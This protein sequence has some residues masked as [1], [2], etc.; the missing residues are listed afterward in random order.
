MALNVPNLDSRTYDQLVAEAQRRILRFTPDWT[1]FNPSDPGVTLVELFA[2]LTEITLYQ[3]NQV[4]DLTYVKFL[5][6]IGLQQNP[7]APAVAEVTFTPTARTA[8]VVVPARSQ[9]SATGPTGLPLVFET[10]Q[11]LALVPYQLTDLVVDDGQ[12]F[13]TV[14]PGAPFRPLGWIP[15][16]NNA[17]YLGFAPTTATE[18]GQ[19]PQELRLL[20]TL[21]AA[22]AAGAPQRA[23][24][25]VRPPLAPVTL[26]WEYL[27]RPDAT[28]WSRL[29][30]LAD[31]SAAFTAQGYVTLAGPA[32]ILPARAADVD[33]PRYWLRVRVVAGR[34]PAGQ[35]PVIEAVT[36]NTTTARNL[37][38]VRDEL[39]G[40]SEAHPDQTFPLAQPPV[41]DRSVTLE[42][43]EDTGDPA[44]LTRTTWTQVSDFLASGPNDRH[45]TLDPA[46]GIVTF[47]NGV[48]GLI[49]AVDAEIVAVSYRSGG[50]AAGNVP[51]GAIDTLLSALPGVDSVTNSRAAAGG[52]DLESLDELKRNAPALLRRQ[53]RAVTAADYASLARQVGGVA[54]ALALPLAHPDHPGV[55]VA[56]SVTV[57][58]VADTDDDPP[59]PSGELI[60]AVCRYLDQYRL[61]ATELYVSG[62]VFVPVSVHAALTIDPYAAADGVAA[63]ADQAL[64]DFLAPLHR[65]ADG[66]RS[67]HFADQFQPTSLYAVL[68][69]V[70]GV[71]AVTAL[72]ITVDGRVHDDPRVAIDLPPG[73]LTRSGTHQL[74]V[75][76]D[77][78]S[79][80]REEV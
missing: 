65:A 4:P 49:P 44:N 24:Q 75:T 50:G 33:D 64:R 8:G 58:V 74:D 56:G 7:A 79:T 13:T 26:V 53:G 9:L 68:L 72:E 45:Y 55:D 38:T 1:D 19:F 46:T 36:A 11:A 63:L 48:R 80:A 54:D 32:S 41:Q 52:T 2:W 59:A 34:Y 10:D 6:L 69:A 57:V 40:V 16:P 35:E 76:P 67:A 15:Q 22:A 25:A 30:V 51:A 60:A 78:G 66:T 37:A 14:T 18:P 3:L 17:L 62:P 5:D 31:G 70:P 20:V 43:R 73:G 27:P 21:S 47:G 12:V 39:L 61:I 29:N 77:S 28:Q 42:V 71:L 23:G